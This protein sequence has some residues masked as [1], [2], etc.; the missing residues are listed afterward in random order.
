MKRHVID[1]PGTPTNTRAMSTHT[2]AEAN[3]KLVQEGLATLLEA[4]SPDSLAHL[5]TDDFRRRR[6]DGTSLG[7]EEWLAAVRAAFVPLA[8]MRVEVRHLLAD[9]DHVMIHTQR[10]LPDGGPEIAVV[11]LWRFEDGL[12]AEAWEIIEP[13][14]EATAHLSWWDPTPAR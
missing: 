9:G 1:R 4:G 10:S 2:T 11:D 12:V 13:V 7:K 8:G 14:A 3:K 5:L 6:P